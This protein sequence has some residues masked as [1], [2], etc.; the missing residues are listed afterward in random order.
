MSDSGL[1]RQ[2]VARCERHAQEPVDKLLETNAHV[3]GLT[4]FKPSGNVG[5]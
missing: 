1:P 3:R 4:F 2:G 5:L